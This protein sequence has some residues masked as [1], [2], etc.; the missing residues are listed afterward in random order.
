MSKQ[1]DEGRADTTVKLLNL[2]AVTDDNVDKLTMAEA[3]N[4]Q[5]GITKRS[6]TK[7]LSVSPRRG[8]SSKF[9]IQLSARRPELQNRNTGRAGQ[10][11]QRGRNIDENRRAGYRGTCPCEEHEW[12]TYINAQITKGHDYLQRQV[13]A[14]ITKPST[15]ADNP[16]AGGNQET[17]ELCMGASLQGQVPDTEG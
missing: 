5:N 12:C 16:G 10:Q 2:Q 1:L 13:A 11:T 14:C 6:T 15:S 4:V 9:N 8:N 3:G 17:N 7:H